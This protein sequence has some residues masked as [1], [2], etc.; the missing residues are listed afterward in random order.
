MLFLTTTAAFLFSLSAK[1]VA[2][3]FLSERFPL[4]GSF[5]GFQYA[6]N[7]GVAFSIR[8]PG[9]LQNILI[10]VALLLLLWAA[11][12]AQTRLSR[13]AFG[14]ILG[15]AA[16]NIADR[17]RDGVV[18]DFLQISSFP[19]F[20][21]ADSCITIGVFLLLIESFWQWKAKRR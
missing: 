5:V 13:I 6:T 11:A 7:P 8:F 16:A 19:I 10:A 17:L 4:L 20:N 14:L 1:L 15:G 21:I 2:D 12:R 18:T 9:P 3:A